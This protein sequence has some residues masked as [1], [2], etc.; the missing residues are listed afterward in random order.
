MTRW[1]GTQEHYGYVALLTHTYVAFE[2]T[3]SRLN[4]VMR[5]RVKPEN[6]EIGLLN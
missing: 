1:S 3:L 4:S 5:G 2:S 6:S